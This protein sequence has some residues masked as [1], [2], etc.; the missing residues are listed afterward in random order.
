M[1][2]DFRI[3]NDFTSTPTEDGFLYE[4]KR[5]GKCARVHHFPLNDEFRLNL[6]DTTLSKYCNQDRIGFMGY[7]MINVNLRGRL[8]ATVGSGSYST[9]PGKG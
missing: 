4:M 8:N 7:L 9:T 2:T 1:I 3:C 6:T 5:D